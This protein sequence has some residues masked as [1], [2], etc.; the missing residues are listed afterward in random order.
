MSLQRDK[1]LLDPYKDHPLHKG[2][3]DEE[4]SIVV[5]EQDSS[6]VNEEEQ[7]RAEWN[8]DTTNCSCLTLKH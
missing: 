5:V 1:D 3:I 4:T 6:S 7:M 8:I 2:S